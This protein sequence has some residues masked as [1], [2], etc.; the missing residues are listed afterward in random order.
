MSKVRKLLPV[1]LVSVFLLSEQALARADNFNPQAGGNGNGNGANNA[2]CNSA[3]IL[4]CDSAAAGPAPVLGGL[5]FV[6]IAAV[7]YC[8]RRRKSAKKSD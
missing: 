3:L 2:N 7:G 1:L 5:G 4:S 6:L 8:V